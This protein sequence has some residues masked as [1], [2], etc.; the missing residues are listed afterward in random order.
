MMENGSMIF[1]ILQGIT[2]LCFFFGVFIINGFRSSLDKIQSS[3]GGLNISITKL[4]EKDITKDQRLDDHRLM[5]TGLENDVSVMR[6]RYHEIVNKSV[7]KI[8]IMEIELEALK[9]QVGVPRN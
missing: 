1:L 4:V 7:A 8:Q 3:I 6:E 9:K 5:I 2:T